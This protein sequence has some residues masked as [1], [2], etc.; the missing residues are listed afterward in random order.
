[1]SR[2]WP[3]ITTIFTAVALSLLFA[4][5]AVGLYSHQALAFVLLLGV[6]WGVISRLWWWRTGALH[7]RM[8][9]DD[10]PHIFQALGRGYF[11]FVLGGTTLIIFPRADDL[12]STMLIITVIWLVVMGLQLF[13]PAHTHRGPTI[14]MLIGA[15]ILTFDTVQALRPTVD[16]VIRIA[17]PFKGEWIVLQ[18]GRSPLQSHHLSA[19]NQEYALDLVKLEDGMIFKEGEGNEH[20]HSWEALLYAPIDGTVVFA[21][22]S[23]KDSEGLNLVSEKTDATGNSVTIKT[24]EGYYVVLAHLRQGSLA[25]SEG[26]TVRSGDFIGKTGNSGNTTMP[27]LHLQVQTHQ[28]IWDPDNRSVPF[29]FDDGLVLERNDRITRLSDEAQ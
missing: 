1:M 29:A 17:P 26:Q 23:I 18:G 28:D 7:G 22:G 20:V 11:W 13:Q 15:F 12:T 3:I 2:A 6:I 16:P 21:K 4:T 8:T 10:Q 25:V 14:A 9:L 19:Y 24:R 27:H 5:R